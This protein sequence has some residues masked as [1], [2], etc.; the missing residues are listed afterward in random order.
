M[1]KNYTI[2]TDS[3]CE[4]DR[5]EREQYGIEYVNM[6]FTLDGVEY[7]ADLDWVKLSA[8]DFYDAMRKGA[9][10]KSAQVN[11][12]QYLE[13]FRKE[14]EKG[15]DIISISCSGGLS[16][17]INISR[18]A[19]EKL[20]K[21]FPDAKIYCIDG[22]SSGY[23][24]GYLCKRA[25]EMKQKG[26]TVDEVA[27]WVE[28]NKKRSNQEGTVDKLTYL[29]NAGRVSAA[30]AFFG[31]ILSVK[32]IIVCDSVG[33]NIAKE[34]VKGRK[35]ALA[36]IA[37]LCVEEIDTN[38]MTEVRVNHAD[39]LEEA[40]MVVD[41]IKAK[42]GDKVTYRIGWLGPIVGGSSGPGTVSAYAFGKDK[43]AENDVQ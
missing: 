24:M 43:R 4:L 35:A 32:P 42:L 14:I 41:M 6:H 39:C 16:A 10:Y 40:Q 22:L 13:A 36:R 5:D 26:A 34:K 11:E 21:E 7:P 33:H 30:A 38:E 31:G 18:A 2:I 1:K 3:S 23:A 25:G 15:N 28:D 37:E 12:A 17:S 29:K 9:K 8:K 27:K 20:L 19:R